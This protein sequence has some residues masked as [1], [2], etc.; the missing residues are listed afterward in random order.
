MGHTSRAVMGGLHRHGA[1]TKHVMPAQDGKIDTVATLND[2]SLL[3]MQTGSSA[4]KPL[5]ADKLRGKRGERK[6]DGEER[7]EV[8]SQLTSKAT[9]A[10]TDIYIILELDLNGFAKIKSEEYSIAI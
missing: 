8:R 10:K 6:R 5:S 3:D 2:L 4:A 1:L 7:E 9:S